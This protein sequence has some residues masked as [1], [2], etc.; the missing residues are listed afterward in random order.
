MNKILVSACLL[1]KRVRYDGKELSVDEGILQDW[2]REGRLVSVCPEVDAGMSIPRAAAEISYGDGAMVLVGS[3]SVLTKAG[4]DVS[5]YF[6][7]GA[8]LA[9]D[10]CRE[11]EIRVAI[12]TEASPSCGSSVIHDGTFSAAKKA[13]EG[14]TTALLRQHGVSVFSQHQLLEVRDALQSL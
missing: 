1:G 13:G 12:L 11:H 10:L 6:L 8:K 9:L 5:N 14:V 4:V 3:S 2:L 7:K